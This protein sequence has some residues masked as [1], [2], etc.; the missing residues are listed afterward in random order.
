MRVRDFVPGDLEKICAFKEKS[1]E[2]SFP[3]KGVDIGIFKRQ[4]LR[5]L[6]KKRPDSI[7]VVET[8]DGSVVAYVRFGIKKTIT[9]E[10][11]SIKHVFVSRD[12][13]GQGLATMLMKEAEAGL[14]ALGLKD[15][16]VVVTKTNEPSMMMCKSLGYR[17]KRAILEK[18][19]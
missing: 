18:E 17:E 11:G 3:G 15:I 16:K 6:G 8:D 1:S 19:I 14:R 2:F 4:I 7:K 9:G 10:H 13:R 12:Y 5:S